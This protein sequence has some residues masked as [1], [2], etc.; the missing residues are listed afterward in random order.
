MITI[1]KGLDL[2]ISGAP[3]QEISDGQ[4]VSTVALVGYDYNGMKPTMLVKE[5]DRVKLGQPV[6]TDKKNEGV[7]YT[8]PASGLV[9]AINRGARRL[10]QSLVIELDG[11]DHE[12]FDATPAD[13]FNTLSTEALRE[14]LVKSGAWTAFR[15]RPYS[16]V[17]AIDSEPA[18]IFVQAMDTNPLAADP[19][20]I[21]ATDTDAF[22]QGL[23]LLTKLT[24]G[25]VWVCKAPG[26]QIPT[27][28][29]VS[30]EEF[31]GV[32]PAGNAGTHI[33]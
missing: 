7:V 11:D 33:H 16:K 14:T 23:T 8:A 10:F 25:K 22:T 15:T 3:R 1:K 21:I 28:D 26:S 17:P 19:A 24:Q 20:T 18:A 29:G 2:P 5:G 31:G 4:P 32:H 30:V 6:F 12:Q 9:K 13:Q 27:A